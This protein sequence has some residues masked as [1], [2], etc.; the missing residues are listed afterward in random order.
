MHPAPFP[1]FDDDVDRA[2]RVDERGHRY[3][4]D[5]LTPRAQELA[6]PGFGKIAAVGHRSSQVSWGQRPERRQ[7][8][9]VIGEIDFVLRPGDHSHPPR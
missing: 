4:F 6:K 3:L 9:S 7:L 1:R 8:L 2:H 5:L